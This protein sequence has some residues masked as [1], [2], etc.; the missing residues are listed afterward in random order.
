LSLFLFLFF[1]TGTEPKLKYYIE[2][3]GKKNFV[4]ETLPLIKQTIMEN[5]LQPEKNNLVVPKEEGAE[6]IFSNKLTCILSGLALVA[7]G[8]LSFFGYRHFRNKR[9]H[10]DNNN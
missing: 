1:K 8:G 9:D 4:L 5:F 10:N 3:N 6:S 2:L 7:L